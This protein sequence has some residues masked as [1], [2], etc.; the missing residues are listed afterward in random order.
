MSGNDRLR[1]QH[2]LEATNEA[3]SF[4]EG[5]TR[6]D[7]TNDRML[8]LSLTREIEI[9]GEAASNVSVECRA[10]LS[11][12]PWGMVVG[13]RN[14]LIHA[15]FDVDLDVIWSTVTSDLPDLIR[16]LERAL[17]RAE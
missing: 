3:L 6:A 10:K 11:A 12:I 4:V 1:L 8:A 16:E 15:Y 2:M 7:L 13:I 17:S 9:I 14:R 5:K